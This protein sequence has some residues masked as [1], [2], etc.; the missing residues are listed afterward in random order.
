MTTAMPYLDRTLPFLD[1]ADDDFQRAFGRHWHWGYWPYPKLATGTIDDYARAAERMSERVLDAAGLA[2]GERLLDVGCGFG[3][4]IA[5]ANA[6]HDDTRLVGLNIDPRQLAIARA[7]VIARAGNRVEFI[8]GNACELP[9]PEA[10]FD[11]LTAVECVFHFPSRERFFQEAARVLTPGGTLVISDFVQPRYLWSH[12]PLKLV[13]RLRAARRAK[14][15][16]DVNSLESTDH[17]YRGVAKRQGFELLVIDDVTTN[18]LPTHPVV[19]RLSE[20]IGADMAAE[21]RD[22]ELVMRLK[23]TAYKIFVFRRS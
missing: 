6:R 3:G 20:R 14:A 23:L 5:I 7:N 15:W 4:T 8:E 9:F 11:R 2:R 16:G 13:Y 12:T 1:S 22:I 21:V 19:A 10:S 18:T 17:F